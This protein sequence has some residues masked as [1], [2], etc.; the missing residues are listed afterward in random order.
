MR[1]FDV[2][3]AIPEAWDYLWKDNL[4]QRKKMTQGWSYGYSE[5][6]YL[7]ATDVENQVRQFALEALEGKPRG[8]YG[9]AYGRPVGHKLII[10]GG[11]LNGAVRDWLLRNPEIEGFNFGR[12]HISGKRFRPKGEPL[13]EAE[14]ETMREKERRKDLP[15]PLHLSKKH[16]PACV[17]KPIRGWRPSKAWM[18]TDK[19]RV[20]CK[21]CK[22]TEAF[23]CETVTS[24]P[25][26][27]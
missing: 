23:K 3:A 11:S 21:R 12:H 4:K 15:R 27:A 24:E 7:T 20:T 5:T 8:S 25:E 26:Y 14:K 16:R 6:F 19:A 2:C 1:A 17:T 10:R 13:A 22:A 9:R 18:T